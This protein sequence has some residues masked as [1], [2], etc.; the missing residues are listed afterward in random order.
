MDHIHKPARKPEAAPSRKRRLTTQKPVPQDVDWQGFRTESTRQGA[1]SSDRILSSIATRFRQWIEPGDI[2]VTDLV[3]FQYLGTRDFR[4]QALH[5]ML[6]EDARWD[7]GEMLHRDDPVFRRTVVDYVAFLEHAMTIVH[8]G[9]GSQEMTD[10]ATTFSPLLYQVDQFPGVK[11]LA[12]T[13]AGVAGITRKGAVY[14]NDE[15]DAALFPLLQ[16]HEALHAVSDPGILPFPLD[17]GMADYFARLCLSDQDSASARVMYP[18]AEEIVRL[19][20]IELGLYDALC[21]AFFQT[22]T[23][24]LIRRFKAKRGPDAWDIFS[25]ALFAREFTVA[26]VIITQPTWRSHSLVITMQKEPNKIRELVKA[27]VRDSIRSL[28]CAPPSLRA[29]ERSN[30]SNAKDTNDTND[31][32]YTR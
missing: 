18:D 11:V 16:V 25:A 19:L 22:H 27:S 9:P 30:G 10:L 3:C 15:A 24:A 4:Y 17:E 23:D 6:D 20:D 5:Q 7:T 8:H 28:T 29:A 13:L 31:K 12:K 21:A 26:E 1:W 32:K 2:P 14:I